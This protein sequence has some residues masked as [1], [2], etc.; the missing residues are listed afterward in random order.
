MDRDKQK[1][2]TI[3]KLCREEERDILGQYRFSVTGI[4]KPTWLDSVLFT[5]EKWR[6]KVTDVPPKIFNI[7]FN[8]KIACCLEVYPSKQIQDI[9]WKYADDWSLE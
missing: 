4:R 3:I 9:A 5:I 1:I 6:G 8:G 7:E 2:E